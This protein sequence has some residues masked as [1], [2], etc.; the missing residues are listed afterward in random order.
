M[1]RRF[2]SLNRRMPESGGGSSLRRLS[3][4]HGSIRNIAV[5]LDLIG[6]KGADYSVAHCG[7]C[8]SR[9]SRNPPAGDLRVCGLQRGKCEGEEGAAAWI[10]CDADTAA[11]R[12]HDFA[13]DGE[14]EAC[15]FLLFA[16]AT[17]E[18]FENILPIVP[19]HAR[20]EEHTSELQS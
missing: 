19:W 16:R 11:M 5:A 17:P 1:A 6:F 12:S 3:L 20:S 7:R 2:S 10:V 18:P 14:A 8:S 4:E 9:V 13:D 15:P